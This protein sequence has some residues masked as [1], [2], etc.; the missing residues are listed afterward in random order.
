MCAC[1]DSKIFQ[2]KY[3]IFSVIC[4]VFKHTFLTFVKQKERT[5]TDNKKRTKGSVLIL[6][7]FT[8]LFAPTHFCI[9]SSDK[10]MSNKH[11]GKSRHPPVTF[12]SIKTKIP[13]S[14]SV[15]NTIEHEVKLQTAI[16]RNQNDSKVN[17]K[18]TNVTQ[19]I[20]HFE[21]SQSTENLSKTTE[22]LQRKSSV[23]YTSLTNPSGKFEKNVNFKIS[24]L[25]FLH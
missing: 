14:R 3:S 5:K 2:Y 4:A 6:I 21:K 23:I 9:I 15:N 20:Q 25:L 1:A 13:R 24:F 7:R 16:K 8:F 22:K 11:G 12:N 18:Q 17:E 10:R 19:L